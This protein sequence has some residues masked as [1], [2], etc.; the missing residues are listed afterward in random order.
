MLNQTPT[1]PFST[2]ILPQNREAPIF[3]AQGSNISYSQP[4]SWQTPPKGYIPFR[5]E[6]HHLLTDNKGTSVIYLRNACNYIPLL[7]LWSQG[8][9]WKYY[10]LT[11][12]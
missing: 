12:E 9:N 7:S 11:W 10:P 5:Y 3:Y 4:W 2:G 1:K 8:S 6:W